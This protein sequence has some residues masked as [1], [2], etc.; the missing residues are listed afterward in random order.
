MGLCACATDTASKGQVAE[1]RGELTSLRE[2]ETRLERRLEWM[3]AGQAVRAASDTP[4]APPEPTGAMPALTVVKLKPRPQPAPP[5]QTRVR[6]HEPD[7]QG[8][9]EL[10]VSE[11][12]LDEDPDI[13]AATYNRLVAALR[14]GDVAG[15]SSKLE[16]FADEHPKD[17]HAD[18]ALYFSG[19]G[20]MGLEDY[21]AAAQRLERVVH[22]YPAGDAVPDALLK[23][24][25]CRMRLNQ[26]KQAHEL[27]IQVAQ[28]YP[29][30]AAA[31]Q[32]QQRLGLFKDA[33]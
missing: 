1:L 3:E 10:A 9:Q 18:N 13:V 16:A 21:T 5:L 33:P 2:R 29:G 15:A 12:A 4:P 7:P 26:K 30:T 32:A 20:L 14:T 25:E 28:N 22:E 8:L 11:K 31:T 6:V 19:L 27:Y 24:A 23:L 17:L